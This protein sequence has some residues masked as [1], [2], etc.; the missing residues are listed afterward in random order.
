[1]I[2]NKEEKLKS[3][4]K[5]LL[6]QGFKF[7]DEQKNIIFHDDSANIIAGPGSGKT[8]VLIAKIALIM[9]NAD[10]VKNNDTRG[11][12]IITHTNVAVDEIKTKLFQ[13]GIEIIKAP[14]FIGT[15]HDFCNTFMLH[16]AY[17]SMYEHNSITIF[18]EKEYKERFVEIYDRDKDEDAKGY[19]PTS[20]ISNTHLRFSDDGVEDIVEQIKKNKQHLKNTFNELLEAGILRHNDI[21][22][23]SMW[24]LEK[25]TLKVQ[26][27]FEERFSWFIFDETQDTSLFQYEIL[28]KVYTN[29]SCKVQKYGDPYQSLYNMFS[30][31]QDAWIP[32]EEEGYM[33]SF[34]LSQSNRFGDPIAKVLQTTCIEHYDSLRGNSKIASF[35]P[36]IIFFKDKKKVIPSFL[37]L[38]N[39]YTPR[40]T[41]FRNSEKMISAVG[42]FHNEVKSYYGN[43]NKRNN[44]KQVN[45]HIVLNFY[46]IILNKLFYYANKSGNNSSYNQFKNKVNEDLEIKTALSTLIQNFNFDKA[47]SINKEIKL[48]FEKFIYQKNLVLND[49]LLSDTIEDLIQEIAELKKIYEMDSLVSY[50]SKNDQIHTFKD[51]NFGT[52]HGVKGETHKATLLLESEMIINR[53]KSN[54]KKVYDCNLIFDYLMGDFTDYS[55]EKYGMRM[56]IKNALK[57]AFVAL[58]RPT[59]LAV[60]AM[61]IDNFIDQDEYEAKVKKAKES[62][63]EVIIV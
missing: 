63:W 18:D 11:V 7:T 38:I 34:E 19:A 55:N 40:D 20:T 26:K 2:N 58:S 44:T 51:I 56:A 31:T 54:E 47:D 1:M 30:N 10:S 52:V 6:P 3:I 62:G 37:E 28:Q 41:V 53:Y 25:Y 42:L 36:H 48:I 27:A 17:N 61:N 39:K 46:E 60:V 32:K 33:K 29:T 21:L 50:S 8:A 5:V 24:Y 14:H 16:Q 4:E 12:C 23:L 13:L 59:H 15:I 45:N 57:T 22:S 35:N 49:N 9:S 43:Y